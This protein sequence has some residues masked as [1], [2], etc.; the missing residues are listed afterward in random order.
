MPASMPAW[1]DHLLP[2]SLVT[3]QKDPVGIKVNKLISVKNVLPFE[4]YS[5]PFCRPQE[6]VKVNGGRR[7][8][9]FRSKPA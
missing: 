4:Y 8:H 1:M 5:L 2:C 7:I 6:I 3:E 9:F